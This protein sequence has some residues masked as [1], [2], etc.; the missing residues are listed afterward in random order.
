MVKIKDKVGINIFYLGL[1]YDY[2]YQLV[3]EK[4]SNY[5]KYK[6]MYI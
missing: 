2:M 1:F 5:Y 6:M 4:K 3:M